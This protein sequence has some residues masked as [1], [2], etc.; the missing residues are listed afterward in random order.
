MYA[1]VRDYQDNAA[2]VAQQAIQRQDSLKQVLRTIPGFIAFYVLDKGTGALTTITLVQDK[3]G[4]EESVQKAAAW[5]REN[6]AQ[7]APTP[8]KVIQGEVI[9]QEP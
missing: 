6:M 9:I 5:V 1:V 4:A 3:A 7:W 2:D 8:P